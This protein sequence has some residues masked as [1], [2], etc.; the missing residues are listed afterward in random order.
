MK[1]QYMPQHGWMLKHY[2]KW[3]KPDTKGHILYNSI[4]YE[5]VDTP[6]PYPSLIIPTVHIQTSLLQVS[7]LDYLI[8]LY[9]N[10]KGK[11]LLI[12]PFY[13]LG[14]WGLKILNHLSKV[15]SLV[16]DRV[17]VQIQI[18]YLRSFATYV[19]H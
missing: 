6:R 13:T 10:P 12:S 15:T 14:N 5:Q 4:I 3:K 8:S 17:R 11:I 9:T 2:A 18:S 16:S 19:C 1:Y 7:Y